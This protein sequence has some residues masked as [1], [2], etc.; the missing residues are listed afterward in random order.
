MAFFVVKV[1]NFN[2]WPEITKRAY[3]KEH[4]F[5]QNDVE[6]TDKDIV[7]IFNENDSFMYDPESE[8][9]YNS[10][11]TPFFNHADGK[12]I[13]MLYQMSFLIF[14]SFFMWGWCEY[15]GPGLAD[16]FFVDSYYKGFFTQGNFMKAFKLTN[17]KNAKLEEMKEFIKKVAQM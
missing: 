14:F 1:R 11:N 3:L 6:M 2:D 4:W 12:D 10:K 17:A 7:S 9:I 13:N 16:T 8:Y 5:E 15:G